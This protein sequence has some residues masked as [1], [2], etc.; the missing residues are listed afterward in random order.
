MSGSPTPQDRLAAAS[1]VLAA[2]ATLPR[3]G[4]SFRGTGAG[5]PP[6]RCQPGQPAAAAPPRSPLPEASGPVA[7]AHANRKLT[8]TARVIP[9][10]KYHL[11]VSTGVKD[12]AGQ[13][14]QGGYQ[15]DFVANGPSPSPTP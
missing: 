1:R 3:P 11:T 7:P 13:A 14:L 2:P 4:A 15:Y 6:A 10:T 5:S 9:G 8:V 12:I